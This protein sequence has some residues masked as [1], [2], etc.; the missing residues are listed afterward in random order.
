[1]SSQRPALRVALLA[2]AAALVGFAVIASFLGWQAHTYDSAHRR[3]SAVVA[4]TIVEDGIGDESDIRVRWA[5]RSGRQH[6]QRFGIYDTDRYTKGR[7]F[8]VA[9]DPAYPGLDGFPGDV[10][11]TSALDDLE[12]PIGLAGVVAAGLLLAWGLRGAL[13]KRAGTRPAE[14][15]IAE[16]LTGQLL[17]GGPVSFGN[18]SWFALADPATPTQPSRWQRVMWHPG[19]DSADGPVGV[20]AHG[21]MQSRGRVVVEL[22]DGSS[23]VPIGRLRHR[24]PTRVLLERRADVRADLRDSFILPAGKPLATSQRWWRLGLI[25]AVVGGVVGAVMGLLIGGGGIAILPFA[26]AGAALAIN[27]WGLT[28]TSVALGTAFVTYTR[29]GGTLVIHVNNNTGTPFY[30]VT[31]ADF[32]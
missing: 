23:P 6:L 11:E 31:A 28:G 17:D 1:M 26:T 15:M 8:E 25:L 13:Y 19:I 9:F 27:G 16:A 10:E 12:V 4:G 24:S 22:A 20:L 18:S 32:S 21:S 30:F 3:A 7:T 5:D 2:V 14:P 29:T